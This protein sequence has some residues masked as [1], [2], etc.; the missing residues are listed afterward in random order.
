MSDYAI[1]GAG[2]ALFSLIWSDFPFVQL[3]YVLV[4]INTV[5]W[6]QWGAITG[7]LIIATMGANISRG[8]R[9]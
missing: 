4:I 8:L 1:A 3:V 6:T 5:D 7:M 2:V 9:S